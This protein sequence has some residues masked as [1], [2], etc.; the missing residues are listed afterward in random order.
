MH[1]TGKV[2][3]IQAVLVILSNQSDDYGTYT[4]D[5]VVVAVANV[6]VPF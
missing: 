2:P 5:V 4:T 6:L 3:P 1:G